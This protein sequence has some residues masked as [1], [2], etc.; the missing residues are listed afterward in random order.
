MVV[1]ADPLSGSMSRTTELF[2]GCCMEATP[3]VGENYNAHPV[4]P[5]CNCNTNNVQRTWTRNVLN[6]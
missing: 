4:S 2:D 1:D 5:Y 6:Y 3:G